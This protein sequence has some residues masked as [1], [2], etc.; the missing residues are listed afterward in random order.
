MDEQVV[1]MY[2]LSTDVLVQAY[3]EASDDTE[4]CITKVY[5]TMIREYAHAK[6]K[7][8]EAED[9]VFQLRFDQT[10]W[11]AKVILDHRL[12]DD[13]SRGLRRMYVVFLCICFPVQI[14]I[15]MAFAYQALWKD[16]YEDF[17]LEG[18]TYDVVGCIVLTGHAVVVGWV[19]LSTL[20]P[21]QRSMW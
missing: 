16:L 1:S 5:D 8:V 19:T 9:T 6:N 12:R 18:Q 2:I 21:V 13:S 17:F 20:G 11:P 4:P 7:L 15:F 10:M 3:P 14:L